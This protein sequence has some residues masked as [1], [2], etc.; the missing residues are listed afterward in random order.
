[1]CRGIELVIIGSGGRWTPE[2]DTELEQLWRT[3]LS[4][5]KIAKA[6]GCTRSAVLG[7]LRRLGFTEDV[8]NPSARNKEPRR[9]KVE[10]KPTRRPAT[11][12]E[13]ISWEALPNTT[14]R[15]WIERGLGECAFPLGDSPSGIQS[16]CAPTGGLT[17]CKAHGRMMYWRPRS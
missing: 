11:L 14:P 16:C 1:M 5:S 7:R 9:P 2:R 15:P 3:G 17:Y 6:V 4:A 13:P 10:D 8:R 12:I